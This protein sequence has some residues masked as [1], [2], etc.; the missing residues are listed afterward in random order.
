MDKLYKVIHQWCEDDDRWL[1]I[2]YNSTNDIIG[3]NYSQ[4]DDYNSFKKYHTF[5]D[6]GLTEFFKLM[7]LD[8]PVELQSVTMLSFINKVCWTYHSATA[9]MEEYQY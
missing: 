9:L 5:L 6:E 8:Y 1:L 2:M 7:A 4:G 3:L